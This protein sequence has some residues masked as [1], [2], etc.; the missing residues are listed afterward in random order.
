MLWCV[1]TCGLKVGWVGGVYKL[2][3]Q[4]LTTT[5]LSV[6]GLRHG[7][8][9]HL[10]SM[11]MSSQQAYFIVYGE[12]VESENPQFAIVGIWGKNVQRRSRHPFRKTRR[13]TSNIIISKNAEKI[14]SASVKATLGLSSGCVAG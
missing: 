13:Q 1:R 10:S 4:R 14:K 6:T 8:W 3:T 5:A 2:R 9:L 12:G 11:S 7:C